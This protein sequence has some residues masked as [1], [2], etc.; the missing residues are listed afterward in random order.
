MWLLFSTPVVE[1]LYRMAGGIPARSLIQAVLFVGLS[2][3]FLAGFKKQL[4]YE[5]LRR[6]AFVI[7]LSLVLLNIVLSEAIAYHQHVRLGILGWN[8]LFD[9]LGAGFGFM[10]F[11]LLYRQCY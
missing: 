6:R 2:H 7:V 8:I 11:R 10:S 9:I 4:K 1:P 5:V 3:L